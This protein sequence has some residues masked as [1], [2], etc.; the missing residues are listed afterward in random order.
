MTF[1][2]K[3]KYLREGTGLCG[4]NEKKKQ[5][6]AQKQPL[7]HPDSRLHSRQSRVELV[8]SRADLRTFVITM[9]QKYE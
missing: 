7:L 8:R 6:K 4:K 9:S 5:P 1:L 2:L 3:G